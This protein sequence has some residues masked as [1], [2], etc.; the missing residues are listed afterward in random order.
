MSWQSNW[1]KPLCPYCG[2]PDHV[3]EN[4]PIRVMVGP[5]VRAMA[6]KIDQEILEEMERKWPAKAKT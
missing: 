2:W 1:T 4:C 6:D 3:W 5:A